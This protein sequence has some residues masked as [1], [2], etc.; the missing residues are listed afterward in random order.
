MRSDN[1]PI[2]GVAKTKISVKRVEYQ[3]RSLTRQLELDKEQIY[4][5][6]E[7]IDDFREEL[8]RVQAP[9]K[10]DLCRGPEYSEI[11]KTYI[12]WNHY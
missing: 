6:N 8:R 12:G 10:P 4:E 5:Q 3:T 2:T 9:E 11:L 7:R 1:R